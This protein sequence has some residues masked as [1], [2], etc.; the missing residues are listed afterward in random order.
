MQGR[1]T[2]H[3]SPH[4]SGPEHFSDQLADLIDFLGATMAPDHPMAGLITN[5]AGPTVP[6]IWLLGSSDQSAALAAHFGK[7]FSFAHFIVGEGGPQVMA[8]YR[9]YF[10]PS[11]DTAEPQGSMGVHVICADTEKDA[12]RLARSRDLWWQRLEQGR[13]TPVPSVETALAHRYSED[14]RRRIAFHRQRQVIGAP[15]QVR[16]K[17]LALGEA[18]GVG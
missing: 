14:E 1:F 4:F 13:P 7:P 15:E 10:K 3:V 8:A 6:K 9:K 11:P 16:D 2:H 18:Y 12:E 17:L 5:P